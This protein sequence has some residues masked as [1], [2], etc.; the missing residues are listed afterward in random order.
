MHRFRLYGE[1]EPNTFLQEYF[2]Q[3]HGLSLSL[4]AT[5]FCLPTQ[6]LVICC[7]KANY[8]KPW[9]LKITHTVSE[10]QEFQEWLRWGLELGVS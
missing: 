1:Y 7:C 2:T 8:L 5:F 3:F 10:S 6:I 4:F 9:E